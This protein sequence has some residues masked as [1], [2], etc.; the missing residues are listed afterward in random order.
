MHPC[1][2]EC[3]LKTL[4]QYLQYVQKVNAVTLILLEQ[5]WNIINSVI[6]CTTGIA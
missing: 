2:T 1:Q 6:S 5:H 4:F 3:V